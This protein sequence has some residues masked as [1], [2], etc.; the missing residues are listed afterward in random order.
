MILN[1]FY[2][3]GHVSAD[4]GQGEDGRERPLVLCDHSTER[5]GRGAAAGTALEED[6]SMLLH[7]SLDVK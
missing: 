3:T 5:P 2:N 7:R 6:H 4:T 1:D